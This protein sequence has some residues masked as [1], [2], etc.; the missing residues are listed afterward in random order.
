MSESTSGSTENPRLT[1]A[2]TRKSAS[3]VSR[4]FRRRMLIC[5]LF[6]ISV[7]GGLWYFGTPYYYVWK[8]RKL[9]MTD[10]A[11]AAIVLEQDVL[12]TS[13]SFPEAEVLWSHALLKSGRRMEALGAFTQ[14]KS[15]EMAPADCLLDLAN[16]AISSKLNT[17]ARIALESVRSGTPERQ[18][19]VET[20]IRISESEGN[21]SQVLVL[22]DELDRIA[23]GR[24][25][26]TLSRAM[27][28]E[29]MMDLPAAADAFKQALDGSNSPVEEEMILRKLIRICIQMA[30]AK[31]ARTYMGRLNSIDAVETSVGD[32]L[33]EARLRRLE[34]DV[35]GATLALNSLPQ[36][37]I[38]LPE[39]LEFRAALNM[40]RRDYPAAI[41]DLKLVLAAEPL[42]KQAHYRIA[43]ALI[44]CGS[45]AEASFHLSENRRLLD[46]SNRI[47]ALQ[48]KPN[49]TQ[50]ETDELIHALEESGMK[51]TAAALLQRSTSHRNE[52]G[53]I[54]DQN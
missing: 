44:K 9:L 10:P 18:V 5:C 19:A 23:V 13:G 32:Q 38:N 53:V 2:R 42:N 39:V 33:N 1:P 51:S 4:R 36:T 34:G 25:T 54:S 31:D 41:A 24:S 7:G 11:A 49:R 15:P 40:D 21:F 52:V 37:A 29:R 8:A 30:H 16:E 22:A 26:G 43:Q 45:T 48:M 12:S 27:A 6:G 28:F 50:E 47:L 20:L 35:D 17:L 14:I 46:L 3:R